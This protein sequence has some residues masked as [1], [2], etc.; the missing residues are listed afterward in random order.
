MGH[1][2]KEQVI[3]ICFFRGEGGGGGWRSMKFDFV[4]G[5]QESKIAILE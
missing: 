2:I 3:N 1:I 5:F 4:V